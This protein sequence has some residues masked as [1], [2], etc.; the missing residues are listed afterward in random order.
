[1][2]PI[3]KVFR[4]KYDTKYG[5]ILLEYKQATIEEQNLFFKQKGWEW[6]YN[7]CAENGTY[8]ELT[9]WQGLFKKYYYRKTLMVL[10]QNVKD[11]YREVAGNMFRQ[12][13]SIYEWVDT[14]YTDK[15]RGRKAINGSDMVDVLKEFNIPWPLTL[16]ENYTYEQYER[17]V[18]RILFRHFE[19][20]KKSQVVNDRVLGWTSSLTADQIDLLSVI[21][22]QREQGLLDDK[23]DAQ[24]TIVKE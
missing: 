19:S 17:M 11:I 14:S 16:I 18:D 21:K 24:F 8:T 2:L 13:Q 10:M 6:F 23:P 9:K 12:H 4:N 5:S 1:M 3:R 20:D 22:K 7:F 15:P